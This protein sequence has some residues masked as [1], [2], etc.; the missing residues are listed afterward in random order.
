MKR[1]VDIGQ[2]KIEHLQTWAV[3]EKARADPQFIEA[4]EREF[5]RKLITERGLSRSE[6]PKEDVLENDS[7]DSASLL[8]RDDDNKTIH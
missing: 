6:T 1:A 3:F 8:E 7:V 2:L 5:G 4:F